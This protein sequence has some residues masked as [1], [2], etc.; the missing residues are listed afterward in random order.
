MDQNSWN[1]KE[2]SGPFAVSNA[3]PAVYVSFEF[4]TYLR[5]GPEIVENRPK[6]VSFWGPNF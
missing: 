5:L 2:C 4:R 1:F 6:I 3:F